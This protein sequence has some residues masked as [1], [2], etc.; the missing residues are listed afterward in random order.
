[1]KVKPRHCLSRS[2]AL[3]W[4]L[5]HDAQVLRRLVW[6]Q[7][8]GKI[9]TRFVPI[10]VT[11]CNSRVR[12]FQ[13]LS[14]SRFLWIFICYLMNIILLPFQT[15]CCTMPTTCRV[16]QTVSSDPVIEVPTTRDTSTEFPKKPSVLRERWLE[17]IGRTEDTIVNQVH[18]YHV[19]DISR[20]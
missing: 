3:L 14:L 15:Q 20:Y 11:G 2:S 19:Y 10:G 1:M 7:I 4:T 12:I 18:E 8:H 9:R 5:K 17:A 16:F 6:Q 13:Q